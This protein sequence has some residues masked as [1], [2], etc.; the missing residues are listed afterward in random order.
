MTD[1][2]TNLNGWLFGLGGALV[3]F[4]C[5]QEILQLSI[6]KK[7]KKQGYSRPDQSPLARDPSSIMQPSISRSELHLYLKS[8]SSR[9]R[10]V[11]EF[12]KS[13]ILI[14]MTGGVFVLSLFLF[15]FATQSLL[16]TLVT[17]IAITGMSGIFLLQYFEN[18]RR[19]LISKHLPQAFDGLI[20]CL[21]SGF[22]LN[23]SILIV[24]DET[25]PLLRSEFRRALRERDFGQS[26]D[27]AVRHMS[28]RL[29]SADLA[30]FATLISVQERS[31]GPLVYALDSL[32]QILKDRERLRQKKMSASAESRMSAAI[33]GGLPILVATALLAFNPAYR[34]TLFY[35]Q[36]GRLL[37]LV[38]LALLSIGSFVMYRLVKSET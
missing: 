16:I 25:I 26:L 3:A 28:I 15:S 21:R 6:K 1:L 30:F 22:D 4:A 37:L 34:D 12:G 31:G 23:R 13:K 36:S 5:A 14:T 9:L 18:E 38:A 19:L 33:L 24:S 35:T 11:K 29:K 7:L 2:I 20:R 10:D 8:L 32:S 17:S 27:E